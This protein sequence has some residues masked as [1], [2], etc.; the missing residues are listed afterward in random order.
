MTFNSTTGANGNDLL[1]SALA[2]TYNQLSTF[3]GLDN[4]WQVFDTAFGTQYNRSLAEILRL[5]WQSG[6]FSQ[7]P[8][9][10]ILDI[11]G[12]ANGAYASSNNKIYLS[13]NFLTTSTAEAISA[14][15]LEE[16][17]HFIDGH[18]NLS[19]S[20]GDEGEKFSA[21]V[22]GQ[23]LTTQ[24][25][26]RINTENDW[27]NIAVEGKIIAV[28]QNT[29][30]III[31]TIPYWNGVGGTSPLGDSNLWTDIGFGQSFIATGN[32][33]NIELKAASFPKNAS[34]DDL[35]INIFLVDL[36]IN[37]IVEL[38]IPLTIARTDSGGSAAYQSVFF[39]N[40]IP[41]TIGGNYGI[42]LSA[43]GL[44]DSQPSYGYIG[45]V[46]GRYYD[47]GSFLTAKLG[48]GLIGDAISNVSVSPDTE[49][50]FNIEFFLT[51]ISL[52]VFPITVIEDGTANLVYTFTR[53][54]ITTNALTVYYGITGTANGSDY[55]GATPG[56]GIITFAAG[57]STTT[58]T[59]DP[60]VDTT[61]ESDETVAVT[62]ATG[63]GYTVGTTTA[64]TGT[65]TNDDVV[66]SPTITLAV[67]PNSVTEDGTAN[68]IYTFTRTGVTTGAL[69]VNYGITG[70][71]DS[72]DYTGATPGTGK[73]ITFAAG[74]STATLTI[75]PTVD[76]TVEIDKTVAV[77]LTT[78]TGYTVGT[79]TAVTGTITNDDGN[80]Q[81]I[82]SLA[83]LKVA[84]GKS[85]SVPLF[86]NTSTNDNTL[87]GIGLRLHYDSSDIVFKDTTNLLSTNLFGNVTDNS[88]TEN[89]DADTN[90]NRYIQFQYLDFAGNW[91]N[92]TLPLKLGDFN[93]TAQSTFANTQLNITSSSLAAGYGLK[94]DPLLVSKQTWNL[95]IDGNGKVDALTDG[96]MAVRYMFGSAF[97]GN[98]LIAGAIAPNATR[99]LSEIQTYLQEGTTQKY[100]DIDGNGKVDA[101][102]DGI[103]AVRYMFGSAFSGNV[104]IAGAIAPDAIRDLSSIQS[105]LSGLNTLS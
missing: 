84:P 91:P 29:Q 85:L 59:I 10:E 26:G 37:K 72:S 13:A 56:T 50:A 25:L 64:V 9:I 27:E 69:T 96:I 67:S 86:Y 46:N 19:D 71:A 22:R 43:I 80:F 17:G 21:L 18:I 74:A 79:T 54:G 15:L 35:D 73:T 63:A 83:N 90:T 34:P 100:L 39:N 28:E 52:T 1:I 14:V 62:L 89:F 68:L 99:S 97:S 70:T 92:Q 93:F 2:L 61:V 32:F 47:G 101:L 60:T 5:Q 20:A 38:G 103:M 66:A 30:P 49:A 53:T 42:L 16:I 33:A 31:S 76:T 78:G 36:N 88:D 77:T 51:Q 41:M 6:D 11:L 45:A 55:T 87:G 65:I 104:L 12:G 48:G 58:L 57:A 75:D 23:N 24:E 44:A 82:T 4:F 98:A 102:T 40:K 94:F 7:L 3:S 105:Y 8:Q 95:D 81:Q